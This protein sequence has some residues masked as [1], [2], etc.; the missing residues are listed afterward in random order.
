MDIIKV[1]SIEIQNNI[2]K[3]LPP[4]TTSVMMKEHID[5]LRVEQYGD[6][7]I[8][9][10]SDYVDGFW[11]GGCSFYESYF[12][13]RYRRQCILATERLKQMR[14]ASK[15]S[16]IKKNMIKS[17]SYREAEII[18]KLENNIETECPDIYCYGW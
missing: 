15:L 5:N 18:W 7:D 1:L 8:S 4:H 16:S 10:F 2:Y 14:Y 3:Y 9:Q 17:V 12:R 11:R 13:C 6:D